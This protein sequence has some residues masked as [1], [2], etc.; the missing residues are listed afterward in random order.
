MPFCLVNNVPLAVRTDGATESEATRIGK[1]TRAYDGTMR[2]TMRG[3]KRTWQFTLVELTP[4]E[5][6]ALALLAEQAVAFPCTGDFV[7]NAATSCY[8]RIT[9]ARYVKRGVSIHKRVA[10]ITL[11][12]V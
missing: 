6:A 10:S 2:S 12:E 3:R 9:G 5:Y 1:E 11:I 7:N 8:V 4:A